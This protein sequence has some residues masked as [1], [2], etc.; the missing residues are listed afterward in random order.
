VQKVTLRALAMEI[1][2]DYGWK[3]LA[4]DTRDYLYPSLYEMLVEY[5]NR[6]IM[7]VGCS[8][9]AIACRLLTDGFNVYGIDA[10]ETVSMFISA[11][12]TV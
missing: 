3:D 7:D 4:D 5:K 12:L 1:Y 11:K 8:N 6:R 2:K 10:S 9:G